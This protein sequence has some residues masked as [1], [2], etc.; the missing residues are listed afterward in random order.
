MQNL[1]DASGE[2][3]G[4]TSLRIPMSAEM[5]V[6]EQRYATS[7]EQI[8]GMGTAGICARATFSWPPVGTFSWPW[9][10]LR[11]DPSR[12]RRRNTNGVGG[13]IEGQRELTLSATT[14]LGRE[15]QPES[16][17]TL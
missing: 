12:G 13:P 5:V 16:D 15:D 14:V 6:M 3:P 17:L 4:R 8:P 1:T 2:I 9:T 10:G 7:P 11:L